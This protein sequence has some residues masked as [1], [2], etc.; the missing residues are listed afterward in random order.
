MERSAGTI[1]RE[2][3][4]GRAVAAGA[5]PPGRGHQSVVSAYE[6]GSRQ[7]SLPT[8]A[9]LVAAAGLELDLRIG[10]AG[11]CV[12]ATAFLVV[13]PPPPS[14]AARDP[15]PLRDGQPRLFGSVARGED[16]EDSDVDSS[17]M[18]RRMSG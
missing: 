18:S 12:R 5:R 9:R 4:S 14:R 1:L 6:S 2:A 11:P 16:S 15:G 10:E 8:L 17:S 3:R 7:P 13:G